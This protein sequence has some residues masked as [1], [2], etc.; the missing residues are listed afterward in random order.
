MKF[1]SL[2]LL[3]ITLTLGISGCSVAKKASNESSQEVTMATNSAKQTSRPN[4][5]VILADDM[6][7]GVTG[8]EGHPIIKTPNIDNLA[9]NGTVFNKGFATSAVCTPSRT[10]LLTGLYER[11]HGI[12]FNSDSS[13]TEEA[14]SQTYPMLLKDAGYFVGWIG[15]NHTPIGKNKAGETGYK[16]GVM[17]NSFDYWYASHGHLT[18][19]PKDRKKH[20]IFK[21][22][23]ADTQIEILEEGLDNFMEP[24]EAFKAG[25]NF[26]DSRPKDKPFALMINFNV[27]HANSTGTMKLRDTDLDLYKTTYRDQFDQVE[28]PE[29]YVASKDIKTPKIPKNV[30]NGEYINGYSY[31]KTP[32]ALRERKI[33]EMQTISGIDKLVGKLVKH[34]DEQGIADNTI[35]VFTSDHGLMH[36]QFGLGGKV[37]LYE[38]SVRVPLVVYDPRLK[39][40]KADESNELVALL[41]IAPTLLDLTDTEI[42]EEMQGHSLKPLMQAD[43]Q[44]ANKTVWR[45]ELFLENMMTIQNYP[46]MEGLRTHKWKY[47]RYFDKKKDQSYAKMSVASINGEQPIYEELFDLENDPLEINN[48]IADPINAD[49]VQRLREKNAALVKEYRG[50]KPFKTY[51]SKKR[52]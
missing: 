22:A 25:Y 20:A 8:Y 1:N 6:R 24:H 38:P 21:N 32:R 23:K 46:R 3:G 35:I 50:D 30:Y 45:Q 40:H 12:N 49:V 4:V 44:L 5:I 15:K 2:I 31:V 7:A 36:G 29:T 27:P 19:Y 48:V 37:L 18:F 39:Q 41:D 10:N 51:V 33:R 11:R 47:I 16:S 14:W 17:D 28:L 26:L 9:A 34:L 42:P 13:M 43:P 52:R